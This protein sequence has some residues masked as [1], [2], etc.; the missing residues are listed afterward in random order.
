MNFT[1]FYQNKIYPNLVYYRDKIDAVKY[2]KFLRNLVASDF[3]DLSNLKP[4]HI[5]QG[6]YEYDYFNF[7]YL[8]NMLSLFI[9]CM[10]HGYIPEVFLNEQ[11]PDSIHW[12]WYFLQ[13]FQGEHVSLIS[14]SPA[15]CPKVK[16]TFLPVFSDIYSPEMLQLWSSLYAKFVRFNPKTETYIKHEFDTLQFSSRHVLGVICRGTDYLRLKPSGHPIQPEI[17]NVI[18]ECRSAIDT[19]GYT[20]IYLA[21]EERKIRDL[22]EEAFPGRILENKRKYYDD[23]Y[24]QNPDIS[25]IK[26]VRFN[27]DNDHYWSGLEYLSSITLLSRCHALIGGNCGGTMA[28]MFMNNNRYEYTHIFNLGLYP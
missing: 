16:N 14:D 11:K 20:H 10:Y 2:K 3:S 1:T 25:Y 28:A 9:Y 19:Y 17:C 4:M 13:P 27:R 23:I 7:C 8:H 6:E 22:F 18:K 24:D 12:D 15:T 26:E 5:L 21:T